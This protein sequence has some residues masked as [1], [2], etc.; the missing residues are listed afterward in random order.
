MA[1][2]G[3]DQGTATGRVVLSASRRTELLHF[4]DRFLEALEK[5]PPE[6]VH[7]VVLW[8]K[9]PSLLFRRDRRE[10]L[11][12]LLEYDQ[13]YVQLSVTGLGSSFLEPGVPDHSKT[14]DML[15]KLIEIVG[16]PKRV[17][18]R[19]DP[20]LNLADAQGH[21]LTNFH[22]F[23]EIAQR[24]REHDVRE[25]TVSWA[26]IYPRVRRRL[27]ALGFVELEA[28]PSLKRR[29][30]RT[31]NEWA[32]S[33]GINVKGCCTQPFLP[34]FGCI[35]GGVLSSLHPKGKSCTLK[36]AA[37]QRKLCLCT[38]SRDIGWY[39]PCP[40]GCV[41]CYAQPKVAATSSRKGYILGCLDAREL[42]GA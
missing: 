19:F 22:M 40:N 8:T 7:S 26:T 23:P 18:V 31:L 3:G 30:A 5:F 17:N 9:T 13:I 2:I 10:L 20:I 36:R 28:S 14:L 35:N 25:F 24:C 32:R 34:G 27:A 38:S 4:P 39:Y 12:R 11:Q 33:F 42:G 37:G 6:T 21:V 1:W 16:S 41:Y 15:P 29:Q